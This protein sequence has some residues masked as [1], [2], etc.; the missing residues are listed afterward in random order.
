M[1]ATTHPFTKARTNGR[2]TYL[3]PGELLAVL[4]AARA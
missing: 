2:M 3:S 4:K 1:Q